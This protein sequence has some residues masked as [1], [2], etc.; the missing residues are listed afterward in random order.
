MN[1][2]REALVSVGEE[3]GAVLKSFESVQENILFHQLGAAQTELHVGVS[4]LMSALPEELSGLSAPGEL[5]GFHE[6]LSA[7]VSHLQ[8]A[9]EAFQRRDQDF[10]VSFFSMRREFCRGAALLYGVRSELPSLAPHWLTDAAKPRLRELEE[11]SPGNSKRTGLF[12]VEGTDERASYA[13]YVPEDYTDEREWPLVLCL[14]GGYGREDEYIW[15]WLRAAKSTGHI[16]LSAKSI[17]V[18]WSILDPRTDAESIL[19]MLEEVCAE[20]IIDR[21]RILLTGLSD[22]GTFTY[23]L[24]LGTPEPF[25]G[26]APIAAAFHPM[27]DALLREGKGKDTPLMIVHGA[28]DSIFPVATARSAHQLFSQLEY[29]VTYEELPDWGHAYTYTVNERIVLPWFSKTSPRER[30]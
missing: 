5:Q 18:T 19:R 21:R 24:G 20:Y 16:V 8:Q 2:Y 3:L 12:G 9:Y 4:E 27:M 29:P 23:L 30:S 25:A 14:H 10:S 15:T 1:E 26:L 22:G 28:H 11:P 13:M 17:G 7:A 6:R